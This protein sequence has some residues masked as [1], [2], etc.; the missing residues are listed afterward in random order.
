[1]FSSFKGWTNNLQI[2]KESCFHQGLQ[3]HKPALLLWGISL[4][5]TATAL[6]SEVWTHDLQSSSQELSAES[7]WICRMTLSF[8]F[9]F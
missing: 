9:L 4:S 7:Y 5:F 3:A 1:M 6:K 8:G 2:S